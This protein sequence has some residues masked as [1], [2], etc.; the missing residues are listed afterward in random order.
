MGEEAILLLGE[1]GS[2]K[3]SLAASFERKGY[4][5]LG[6]DALVVSWRGQSAHARAVYPSLRLFPDSIQALFSE[7]IP[8]ASVA[9]YTPKLRVSVPLKDEGERSA[10]P[11]RAIFVLGA[12]SPDSQVKVCRKSIADACMSLVEGSFVLDPTDTSRAPKRLHDASALAR[13][14][15]VFD[16][17]YP[18]AYSRLADVRAAIFEALNRAA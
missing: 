1:S 13:E 12:P 6:D 4:A 10:L 15:P 11:I 18:R 14:V 5:L 9:H 3:S 8:T 7:G 16:L 2:G 17:S